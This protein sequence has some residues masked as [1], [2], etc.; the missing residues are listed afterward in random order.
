MTITMHMYMYV[1]IN[2]VFFGYC[3][4]AE[5]GYS[6]ESLAPQHDDPIQSCISDCEEGTYKLGFRGGG[7]GGGG[8]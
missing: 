1:C 7:R 4:Q 5:K 6:T 8:G 2:W 3:V